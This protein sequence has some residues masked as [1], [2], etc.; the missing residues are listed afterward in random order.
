MASDVEKLK[1]AL[2]EFSG[3][4]KEKSRGTNRS[5]I[6]AEV[7]KE[8]VRIFA[9]IMKQMAEQSRLGKAELKGIAEE[10]ASRISMPEINV[11]ELVLPD[12]ELP[13]INVPAPQVTVNLDASK[14]KIPDVHMPDHM[15]IK[16]WINLMG[17]DK[18][19]LRNPL[20]VQLRD[21]DG[22]PVN[23]MENLTTIIGGSSGGGSAKIVKISDIRAS[24]SSLIDEVEGALRVVDHSG[25]GGLTD[26]ELRAL[27]VP[28]EQVSGSNWSTNV[29]QVG[30]DDVAKGSEL[31][32][33][34]LRIVQATDVGTS[35]NAQGVAAH[36]AAVSGNPLLSGGEARTT[37]PTAVG[38][39][40]AVRR[41]HDVVGRAVTR[42]VHV[43]GLLQTAYV[44]ET[45]VEEVAI[46]A[47]A[48]GVFHD[49]VYIMGANESD[50][51]INIDIRQ[52]TGGNV[53]MTLAIPANATAGVAIPVPI[54]QDHADAS[55]TAQNNA[56]DN[57]N[58]IYSIT[59]LFSIEV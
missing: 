24:A 10:I 52:T 7:S 57:S 16:G 46:L 27:S 43:R 31:S 21:S 51:A 15:D 35:T 18:G 47:G 53:Q 9:P 25:G 39:G 44:T 1:D 22:K 30:G 3:V 59:A 56:S 17:Y 2:K 20:P 6:V 41:M 36:D 32:D 11:P 58:T 28:V 8:V 13:E 23:M 33:G 48:S 19:L 26:T 4:M 37:N 45:E 5:V 40:D 55:W 14:I 29:I 12:I 50:A 42:P 38:D 49:L 54:P 34:F